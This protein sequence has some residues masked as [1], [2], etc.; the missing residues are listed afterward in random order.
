MS[1]VAL[2]LIGQRSRK[3]SADR[4]QQVVLACATFDVEG[5]VDLG[6]KNNFGGI[7]M[8]NE[9]HIDVK[10]VSSLGD[11]TPDVGLTNMRFS[12]EASVGN[13]EAEPFAD[14]LVVMT[15]DEQR[16]QRSPQRSGLQG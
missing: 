15:T 1:L 4:A 13:V 6:C 8:S 7:H 12:T 3:L 16:R 9:V 14:E 11:S 2:A 5:K 10:E